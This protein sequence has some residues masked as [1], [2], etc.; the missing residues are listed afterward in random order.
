[1]LRVQWKRSLHTCTSRLAVQPGKGKGQGFSK[2]PSTSGKRPAPKRISLTSLYKNWKDTVHTAK[3]NAGAVSV[4][5]PTLTNQKLFGS[6][7]DDSLIGKVTTFS[8]EQCKYLHHLGSFKKN[9]FRELFPQPVSLIRRDSTKKFISIMKG[10]VAD[11]DGSPRSKKYV[12]TGESGVGKTTLLAQLHAYTVDNKGIVINIPYPEMFLNGRNDFFWDEKSKSYVQ[13]M[14]LKKL[15][16]KI[17]KGNDKDVLSSIKLSKDYKFLNTTLKGT[18]TINLKEGG[19]SMYDLL[20]ASANP[21]LRGSQFSA[22]IEEFYLQKGI[23]I[24]FTVDNVSRIFTSSYSE[25]KNANNKNIPT[26]S[27]QLTKTIMNLISGEIPLNNPQSCVVLAISGEDRTNRTL[28]VALGQVKEDPYIK[29][30]YYD[31]DFVKILQNGGVQEFKVPKLNCEE[32][33][34]LM[35]FYLESKIVPVNDTEDKSLNQLSAEKYILSGNGNPREL[36]RSITLT[37]R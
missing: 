4:D 32:V 21:N 23:P 1:M 34:E 22:I 12:I 31:P 6:N 19:S 15:I 27:F 3:L 24:T 33:Q 7:E 26:L 35:K 10:D 30:Y 2:A 16:K 17:L 20:S 13:P 11:T 9:Q 29:K 8:S 14:Y 37:R 25:Y 5:L 36:L 28:P 18:Q